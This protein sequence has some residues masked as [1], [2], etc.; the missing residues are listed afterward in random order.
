MIICHK[1]EISEVTGM[2]GIEPIL[3]HLRY[4]G[5]RVVSWE[6]KFKDKKIVIHLLYE[7][8]LHNWKRIK[9]RSY[10]RLVE[11]RRYLRNESYYPRPNCERIRQCLKCRHIWKIIEYLRKNGKVATSCP[12]CGSYQTLETDWIRTKVWKRED[13]LML[14]YGQYPEKFCPRTDNEE[15]GGI[16]LDTFGKARISIGRGFEEPKHGHKTILITKNGHQMDTNYNERQSMKG[17]VAWCPN[18]ARV[19]I[20]GLGLGLVLLYLAKTGKAKEVTVCEIDEDVIKLVE[21]RVR[22]WL[23]KHCPDFKWKV[24]HGDALEKVLE[25][26]PYDWIFMDMWKSSRNIKFMQKAETVAKKNLAPKGRVTCWM[27]DKFL[28]DERRFRKTGLKL[29]NK[30]GE[31]NLL[32][33]D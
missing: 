9:E 21:P 17:A 1:V 4:S 20:G 2:F 19:F 31:I 24:V 14:T 23:N 26:S 7:G 12:K 10:Y 27:M 30:K 3:D 11:E 18:N 5:S 25:G 29:F 16:L 8:T 28:K 15:I 22:S 13:L 32:E 6:L 33:K